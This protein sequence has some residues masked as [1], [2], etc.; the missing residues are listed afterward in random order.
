MV[1][2]LIKFHVHTIHVF[3]NRERDLGMRSGRLVPSLLWVVGSKMAD[4]SE[5]VENKDLSF[6]ALRKHPEFL[7]ETANLLN[8]EWRKTLTGRL[9]Y[10][11]EGQDDLPCSLILLQ[12]DDQGHTRVIGHSR[13]N[14]VLGKPKATFLTCVLIEKTQRGCGLGKKLMQLTET[15]VSQLGCTA[16]YLSTFEKYEFYKHLGYQNCSEVTP[17]KTMS[18]LFTSSQLTLLREQF[19]ERL[20]AQETD[21]YV[22]CSSG[23]S[24]IN[25]QSDEMSPGAAKTSVHKQRMNTGHADDDIQGGVCLYVGEAFVALLSV[26]GIL[27]AENMH[28]RPILKAKRGKHSLYSDKELWSLLSTSL[29]K[30]KANKRKRDPDMLR[31]AVLELTVQRL[32]EEIT[33]RCMNKVKRRKLDDSYEWQESPDGLGWNMTASYQDDDDLLGIDDFFQKLSTSCRTRKSISTI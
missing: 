19:G 4:G 30:K 32:N 26:W 9:H 14:Q 12:K 10:L 15:Y 11:S 28:S 31:N 22:D 1:L 21:N 23:N 5:H 2:H 17:V 13:L 24:V 20:E 33:E 27:G 8:S 25:N 6:A 29:E 16:I 7:E 3:V 18:S